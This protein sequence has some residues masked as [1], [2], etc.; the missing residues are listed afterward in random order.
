M[1]LAW[2]LI[3]ML[4]VEEEVATS[5]VICA[6]DP[7]PMHFIFCLW[8]SPCVLTFGTTQ[9]ALRWQVHLRLQIFMHHEE[10]TF[11]GCPRIWPWCQLVEGP[12]DKLQSE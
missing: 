5:N 10:N 9:S 8:L 2:Y 11:G 6:S 12:P 4:K 1:G 7:Q 3:S